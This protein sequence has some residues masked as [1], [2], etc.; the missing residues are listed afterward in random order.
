MAPTGH[1]WIPACAGMTGGRGGL[2]TLSPVGQAFQ[3]AGPKVLYMAG[4]KACPTKRRV[5][6]L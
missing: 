1:F 5:R 2:K 6:G 3:P 4:W